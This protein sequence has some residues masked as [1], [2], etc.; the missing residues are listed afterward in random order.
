MKDVL[1][2]RV[3]LL[4]VVK[5]G[6]PQLQDAMA[7]LLGLE[8]VIPIQE[9]EPEPSA[10][11]LPLPPGEIEITT[12]NEREEHA[13][14]EVAAAVEFW[15]ADAFQAREPLQ[16]TTVRGDEGDDEAAGGEGVAATRPADH[17][18]LAS[19]AALLSRVRRTT[20]L[21]D[22]SGELDLDGIVDRLVRCE[23]L[24]RLPR[25]LRRRWGPS[26]Q[27]IV[28]RSRRL[29]PYWA[30][31]CDAVTAFER[32][33]P[34]SHFQVAVLR[35]G[36]TE[37]WMERPDQECW[38]YQLPEATS[39]IL[40]LGDLGS[41]ARDESAT[42]RWWLEWGR[43]LLEK[44]NPPLALVPCHPER[45]PSELS[46]VWTIL[47]WENSNGPGTHAPNR[48]ATERV[49]RLILRLLS[50]SPRVEPR[51]IRAVR[52]LL[53]EGRSDAGIESL[54][55]QDESLVGQRADSAV[56]DAGYASEL[57]TR[58]RQVDPALREQVYGLVGGMLRDTFPGLWHAAVLGLEQEVDGG[59]L[60]RREY[61]RALRWFQRWR[62]RLAR[63]AEY[64][65]LAGDYPVWFRDVI[66][67]QL[68]HV[69]PGVARDTLLEIFPI[70]HDR[71]EP[72]PHSIDPQLLPGVGEPRTIMLGQVGD[73]VVARPFQAGESSGSSLGLIGTRNGRIKIAPSDT[74]WQGGVRPG[75][76]V[77]W[78]RDQFG[79]WA[80]LEVGGVRQK[81][82]WIPPGRFLMGSPDD[83]ETSFG[84]GR[85]HAETIER[86]FWLF[87]TPCTQALWEVVMRENPSRFRGHTRPVEQVSWDDAQRF[88]S[89]MAELVPGINLSLPSETQW[90]YACRAGTGAARWYADELSEIAWYAENSFSETHSV[91]QKQSNGWGLHDMLGNVWEWCE[92]QCSP[93]GRGEGAAS[94][95]G[96]IRGSSWL[97]R[98]RYIRTASRHRFGP[99][100]RNRDLGFRCAE[101]R[102]PGP[103]RRAERAAS[104]NEN[105]WLNLAGRDEDRVAFPAVVPVR[106]LS[107]LE[108]LTIRTLVRPA[109]ASDMGRD[110]YGLWADLRISPVVSQRLRWIPPGRFLMGSP[111]GEAGR[112]DN[113]GP[114]HEVTIERGFWMFATPCTQVLWET[115]MAGN[116]S[117]FQSPT[118]PV[119]RVSWNDCQ[120]FVVR[121]NG[122]LE[123]LELSLPSEA[124][125]EYA[126][127]AG[128]PTATYAGDL[129][130]LGACNAPLLDGIAWYAGN[131]GVGFEL[132]HGHHAT[133]WREKQ[134]EFNRGGTRPVELKRPNGW[135]LYDML[136]NVWEWCVDACQ[137][138]AGSG[139]AASVDRAIRG[140]SWNNV[141]RHVQA[142]FRYGVAPGNRYDFIGFRCAEFWGQAQ[143]AEGP[144]RAGRS[145]GRS[146]AESASRRDLTADGRLNRGGHQLYV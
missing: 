64:R 21:R 1:T 85:Q 5:S 65:D 109:W 139:G 108:E 51:M 96:V 61:E 97:I 23:L 3:D 62:E 31:Q 138:Y 77:A 82:R 10:E 107:D 76:A 81:L 115:V 46:D 146:P 43:R 80:T 90:E 28:D 143:G 133:R 8:R 12:E 118:R 98:A 18:P 53:P 75:W 125:W 136:G 120:E 32:V 91:G 68:P 130:I 122:R 6:S 16:L 102:S 25:L 59:L 15:Q 45:C 106:V 49:V 144:W 111:D 119:E 42:C 117:R 48:E 33:Y 123:G 84:K 127:R 132:P 142:A 60:G 50:F 63:D 56:F 66:R 103:G 126:C 2:G 9:M 86:G 29:I 58:V 137:P 70:V 27:I 131:C 79:V 41:L 69:A 17:V 135:G 47:P 95:G 26:L 13:P 35:E 116:P 4:W 37:P 72:L 52:R 44:G 129:E 121:L 73:Q 71:E 38:P 128:T 88:M 14:V 112:L 7:G 78:G 20:P 39:P 104:E 99:Q 30:D 22:E 11:L 100:Y 105:R 92:E 54:V 24:D 55:W 113:E 89:R 57:R 93:Y 145:G 101:S 94:A 140:G 110:R 36:G 34:R 134:Y 141:P 114:Q 87:D 74:F 83:E 40:V 19:P 124:Q 67:V